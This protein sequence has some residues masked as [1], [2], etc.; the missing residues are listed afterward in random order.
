V[1]KM[2]IKDAERAFVLDCL[3]ETEHDIQPY[4]QRRACVT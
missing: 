1:S 2:S 4:M 3:Q